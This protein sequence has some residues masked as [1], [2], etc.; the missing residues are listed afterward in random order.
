MFNGLIFMTLAI[1]QL[2]IAIAIYIIM[3][4]SNEKYD[5]IEI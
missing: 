5:Y 3:I 2:N 1:I 4:H